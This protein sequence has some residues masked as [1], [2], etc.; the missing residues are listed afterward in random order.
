MDLSQ[1]Q[2]PQERGEEKG[3]GGDAVRAAKTATVETV[4][5]A[6]SD[7]ASAGEAGGTVQ[8]FPVEPAGCVGRRGGGLWWLG[9][10]LIVAA[11]AIIVGTAMHFKVRAGGIRGREGRREGRS[12]HDYHILCVCISGWMG[13]LT[14]LAMYAKG[15]EHYH[16]GFNRGRSSSCLMPCP[17]H[18]EACWDVMWFRKQAT[19]ANIHPVYPPLPILYRLPPPLE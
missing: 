8:E 3:G 1:S 7:G 15:I 17:L 11:S 6:C 10:M 12:S 13:M 5:A 14:V 9:G 2:G 16:R 4:A 18:V 19:N